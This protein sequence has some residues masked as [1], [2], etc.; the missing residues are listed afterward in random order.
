MERK[1]ALT[2]ADE[3]S[4]APTSP[5]VVLV[6]AVGL[7]AIGT[8]AV[9]YFY[10][11]NSILIYNDAFGHLKIARFVV[12]G[13][14]PGAAQLGGVWL[15]LPHILMLPFIWNDWAFR[16]GIAGSIASVAGFVAAGIFIYFITVRITRQQLAGLTALIVFAANPNVLYMQSLPMTELPLLAFITGGTYF[17]V[18]WAEEPDRMVHL[19][20]GA[21]MAFLATMTRYEGWAF[22]LAATLVVGYVAG[23]KRLGGKGGV[24]AHAITFGLFALYGIPLWLA[25]NAILFGDPFFFQSGEF[26]A[27]A[28]NRGIQNF[29]GA[30]RPS[31]EGNIVGAASDYL[32]A[33]YWNTGVLVTV[34]SYAGLAVWF[35]RE[36]IS[37]S[38]V[39]IL[40]LAAPALMQTFA[41]YS[42][43]SFL[44][45][46]DRDHQV[47]NIRYGLLL[48]P[49]LAV[50]AGY[51]SKFHNLAKVAIVS[52]VLTQYLIMVGGANVVTY[53]DATQGLGGGGVNNQ[54]PVV[55]QLAP[56]TDWFGANYDSGLI[57]IDSSANNNV[58]FSNVPTSNFL[59]EG[60]YKTWDAALIDPAAYVDWIYMQRSGVLPDR[61]WDKLH[62]S[63]KLA[64]FIKVREVGGIVIYVSRQHYDAWIASTNQGL[65]TAG[66]VRSP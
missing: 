27:L 36:K 22:A 16:T 26:S 66:A 29:L 9:V 18:K 24:Q 42:G 59:H 13:L 61:V 19:M 65:E 15:P 41:M 37:P 44:L 56:V 34:V 63:A 3:P 57:L 53:I 10:V 45:L 4:A 6:L 28:I 50:A 46:P 11:N 12:R 52:L 2:R 21:T 1:A 38:Q 49:L 54:G 39:G 55:E 30:G 25:W 48:L 51:L 47:H 20:L 8:A 62:D 35:F 7:A 14:Q 43:D 60:V 23:R 31:S 58:F 5:W 17:V 33:V 32:R 64:D 40:L